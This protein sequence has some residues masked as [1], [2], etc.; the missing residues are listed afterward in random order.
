MIEAGVAKVIITPPRGL[1]LAGYFNP[2]PNVGVLDDLHVRCVLFRK[3]RTVCGLVSLEVCMISA[4][5]VERILERLA[6]AGFR[7]GNGLLITATH[8]HTAPYVTPLFGTDPD[9]EYLR[10]LVDW[11]VEAVLTAERNLAPSVLKLGG[12]KDNPFAFIRRYWMKS[13]GVMTNPGVKNPGIVKPESTVDRDL[14]VLAIEQAGRVVAILAHIVNHTD[15]VGEDRVSADWPGRMERGVQNALG[16]DPL[17]MT[18]IGCSGNVNHIDV[19]SSEY[20]GYAYARACQIGQGYAERVVAQLK[21]LKSVEVAQLKVRSSTITIPFRKITRQMREN[22]QAV[23]DRVSARSSEG[24]MTSEGLATGD[25]PVARFF[26]EQALLYHKLCSGKKRT[27]RLV[28]LAFGERFALTSLPGEPFTEI[29]LAI[30]RE[31][32]FKTTWPVSLSMG[33][34]GYVPLAACFDRGG[35]ETLPVVGGGAREDTAE[36][37]IGKT[38][39]SLKAVCK[40]SAASVA[41]TRG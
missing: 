11:T 41:N 4:E 33:A 35:Y 3:G 29:G 16:Y 26:A 18:L 1:P 19:A 14:G 32:P 39:S 2:R 30:K 8:S 27:F 7:H 20:Q 28:T 6:A 22:A 15:S 21:R 37:L 13:G 12:V 9:P 5:L 34:C 10:S 24:D 38:A 17:V 31:S 23:L 25:G 36:R 40:A